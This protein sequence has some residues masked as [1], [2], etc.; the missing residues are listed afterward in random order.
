[1]LSYNLLAPL[2]VRPVDSRTGAV[3]DYAAFESLAEKGAL[4]EASNQILSRS[5]RFVFVS[6]WTS[7]ISSC[8]SHATLDAK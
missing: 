8:F 4:I 3:Q 1:M 6:A 5:G 2:F 7:E